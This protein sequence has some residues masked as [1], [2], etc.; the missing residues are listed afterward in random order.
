[1]RRSRVGRE[2]G[3][4]GRSWRRGKDMIKIHCMGKILS[5]EIN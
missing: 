3:Q 5:N 1:M 4:S 2:V